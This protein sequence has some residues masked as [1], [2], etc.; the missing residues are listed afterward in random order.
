MGKSART[1]AHPDAV[2]RIA[3]MVVALAAQKKTG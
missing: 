1:L 3:A 2:Q